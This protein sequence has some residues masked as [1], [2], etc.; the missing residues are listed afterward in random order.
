MV[1]DE[2]ATGCLYDAAAVG[3]G[4]VRCALAER[5]TLGHYRRVVGSP[6]VSI[7]IVAENATVQR[8]GDCRVGE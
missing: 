8:F 5:D 6:T 3:G 7:Q 2:L 4:V 1:I